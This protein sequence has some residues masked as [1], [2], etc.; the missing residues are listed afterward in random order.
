MTI[1]Q[2]MAMPRKEQTF[3]VLM[4]TFVCGK[5]WSYQPENEENNPES[6]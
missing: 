4:Q 1:G 2:F 3:A 5:L 6:G